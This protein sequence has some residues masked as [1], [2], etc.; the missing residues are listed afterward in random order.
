MI[1]AVSSF[2]YFKIN[3]TKKNKLIFFRKTLKYVIYAL[4]ALNNNAAYSD[5]ITR[6][7]EMLIAVSSIDENG[8]IVSNTG[9]K[10]R[11]FAV[12][13]KPNF[14][15]YAKEHLLGH[16]LRCDDAGSTG[17]RLMLSAG[18]TV[19]SIDC[20]PTYST[21][22]RRSGSLQEELIASGVAL[23]YCQESRNIFKTC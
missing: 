7:R 1:N 10:F 22:G 23:E 16:E 14:L 4:I 2:Q 11:I 18:D 3:V 9:R 21:I 12:V 6:N 19:K 13:L 17:T 20:S 8:L 15:K 5:I